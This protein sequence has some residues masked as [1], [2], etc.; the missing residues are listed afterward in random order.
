MPTGASSIAALTV[1]EH[2]DAPIAELAYHE[3]AD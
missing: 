1:L 2:A 3:F